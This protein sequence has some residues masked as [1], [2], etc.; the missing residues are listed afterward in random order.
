MAIEWKQEYS[1]GFERIDN[2]HKALIRAINKLYE[3]IYNRAI[4][5]KLSEVLE[6]LTEYADMH[7]ETEEIYFD[8]FGYE[9]AANHKQEH[10][11]FRKKISEVCKKYKKDELKISFDLADF[12]EDWLVHH[13]VNEDQK[14]IKCFKDNGLT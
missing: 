7:F 14:Y 1:I 4:K 10:K 12:L 5:D 11:K 6:E 2:Q 13:L 8:K 3:A 9:N